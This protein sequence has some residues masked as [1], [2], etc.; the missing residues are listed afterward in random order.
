MFNKLPTIYIG[1]DPTEELYCHVLKKSIESHTKTPYNIVPI[2]QSEVRRSGL[3][4]RSGELTETGVV[5]S[6]DRKPFSTEF[7]FTRF[8]VPMLN[9]YSGLA[10]FMDCDMFVRSDIDEIFDTAGANSSAAIS[11]VKHDYNPSDTSKMGGKVQTAYS[12][13]NWSSFVLWNCDHFA[14]KQLTVGDVNTKAGSWL[15]SFY[16][17][18]SEQIGSINHEWNWLDGH[19]PENIEAK[20]VHF[21]TGG[22]I[23]KDWK[24]SRNIDSKY[25]KEWKDF[26]LGHLKV[27]KK[28]YD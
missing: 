2:V 23:Y 14:N 5:D 15:H 17:L 26:Y 28:K 12:R 4:W 10:L 1:Y 8:L 18:E 22:P 6:F 24:P 13:K 21:T 11:C 19:S 20:N 27:E 9:Q 7:S 16:W 25:V 3:Y